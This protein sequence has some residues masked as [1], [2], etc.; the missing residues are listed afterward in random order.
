MFHLKMQRWLK[1]L[2]FTLNL[3]APMF[4]DQDY[5]SNLPGIFLL[6]ALLFSH[7]I[8]LNFVDHYVVFIVLTRAKGLSIN[9]FIHL[10][11]HFSFLNTKIVLE[12]SDACSLDS[13][14]IF[15]MPFQLQMDRKSPAQRL[16]SYHNPA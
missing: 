2:S 14:N 11:I 6:Y 3:I 7:F 9:T 1:Y 16:H 8:S 4:K 13:A 10:F 15:F 12:H 5:M